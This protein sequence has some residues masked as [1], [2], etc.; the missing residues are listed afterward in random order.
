MDETDSEDD[1]IPLSAFLPNS[2]EPT[3]PSPI[4]TQQ[5]VPSTS[6]APRSQWRRR[7]NFSPEYRMISEPTLPPIDASEFNFLEYFEQ[8]VDDEILKL[9]VEKSN[10]T[11]IM[12]NGRPLNLSLTELKVF[13]GISMI[14]SCLQYPHIRMYWENRWRVPVISDNMSRTRFFTLR[15]SLKVVFDETI[16]ENERKKD[17]LWKLRPLIDRIRNGCLIQ[18]RGKYV[19]V[20]EMM[21]PFSG[22]CNLKQFVP[23]KP[24]PVGLKIFVLANPNG[25]VLDYIFYQG[26]T[27]FPE[28]TSSGF[29]LGESSVIK[30]TESLTPGHNIYHDRYFTSEKLVNELLIRGFLSTGT[31]NSLRVPK[32]ARLKSDK[33][34]R[35]EGRGFCDMLVRHDEK[36]CIL[37]WLDRKSVTMMSSVHGIEP[38]DFCKRYNKKEKTKIQ[39]KRPAAVREYNCNMGGVDLA[40][41]MLSYC[42]MRARTKKWTIRT[43]FHLL[44]MSVANAWLQLRQDKLQQGIA[45]KKIP[46]MRKYK[47]TLGEILIYNGE[48]NEPDPEEPENENELEVP[49]VKKRSNPIPL[50]SD[51]KRRKNVDHMPVI[52][53]IKEWKKC[54]KPGCKGKTRTSC[55]TCKVFLC[56]VLN[57]NCFAEFHQEI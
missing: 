36:V 16:T 52:A 15:T 38:T 32:T 12:K 53:D 2:D 51:C 1:N 10:Q 45:R 55:Q 39:V 41:R 27:T 19:C 56:L 49:Q 26:E 50:P 47:L 44:D 54:R 7:K 3:T 17:R 42:P 13:I 46:Q 21:V 4:P 28:L 23:N 18:S 11:Y 40:D 31:I 8:Y 6:A 33:E 22:V 35:K 29:S 20:D 30:L 25:I 34:M 48:K 24:N 43:I 14:M 37:K 5:L 57:R 9:I